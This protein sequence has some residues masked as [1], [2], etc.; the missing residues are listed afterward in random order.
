MFYK[1]Q[2]EYIYEDEEESDIIYQLNSYA[3]AHT[4]F[5]DEKLNLITEELT[6]AGRISGA[7]FNILVEIYNENLEKLF[8]NR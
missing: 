3:D 2:K 6:R 4:N 7:Q 5:D 1:T 8:A